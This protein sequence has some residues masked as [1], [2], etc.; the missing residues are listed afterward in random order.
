ME[1]KQWILVSVAVLLAGIYVC[2]FTAWF[3]PQ[4]IQIFSVT[5]P[6]RNARIGARVKAAN[7]DTAIVTF[8]LNEPYRL[9]EIKV[10]PLAKWETNHDALPLW[11]LISD[12]N[13]VP[14]KAFPYGAMLRGMKP[15]IARTWPQPLEPNVTYRLFVSA[16]SHKGEHDFTPPPK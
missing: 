1:K 4:T 5:R 8:G 7:K 9:T 11:H 14:V 13:S 12:S 3:R 15:A 2:F 6:E 10:V 16:G